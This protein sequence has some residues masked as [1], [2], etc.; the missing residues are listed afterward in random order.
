[1]KIPSDDKSK[2]FS[3]VDGGSYECVKP[4]ISNSQHSARVSARSSYSGKVT[5]HCI[6]APELFRECTFCIVILNYLTQTQT[7]DF[8]ANYAKFRFVSKVFIWMQ[9]EFRDERSLPSDIVER[10]HSYLKL[11]K[12][13]AG[14][15]CQYIAQ[16][17][18]VV[19]WALQFMYLDKDGCR[20][21]E[22][23]AK[24][25]SYIPSV[26]NTRAK[27]H[28]SLSQVTTGIISDEKLLVRSCM[29]FCCAFLQI[30][31][32]FRDA[33]RRNT[34]VEEQLQ[35]LL[36]ECK[37]DISGLR[38]TAS[39][40]HY[41][42]DYKYMAAAVFSSEDCALKEFLLS[43]RVDFI[44]ALRDSGEKFSRAQADTYIKSGLTV[45]GG[46]EFSNPTWPGPLLFVNL[47]YLFLIKHTP[48]EEICFA[49]LLGSDRIQQAGINDL[50]L[51][52]IKTS[53]SSISIE[54]TKRR[55]SEY[56]QQSP[57]HPRGSLRYHA[58][59][60]YVNVRASFVN[61]FPQAE[62]KLFDVTE[63]GSL[64]VLESSFFR[65]L[66][67][68]SLPHTLL[69][70]QMQGI[71]SEIAPFAKILEQIS[72]HNDELRKKRVAAQKGDEFVCG[73]KRQ[74]ITVN[75]IAHSRAILDE[76]PVHH[77][78]FGA[79]KSEET[80]GRYSEEVVG[81][82]ATAHS[83]GVKE[84]YYIHASTTKYRL[85]KRAGFASLVGELMVADARK[86]NDLCKKNRYLTV[87]QIKESLGWK[88]DA[89]TLND[90]QEFDALL[91]AHQKQGWGI[92]PFGQLERGEDTI[93]IISPVAAALLI[94]YREEC[95]NQLENLSSI[96]E[97]RESALIMQIAYA[98][99]VLARFD[100]KTVSEAQDLMRTRKFPAPIIR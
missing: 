11:R 85:E 3:L 94:S 53:S 46:L 98:D 15:I 63:P 9:E 73:K 90:F 1:M 87:E 48:A 71:S 88:A 43:N 69:Y 95:S 59:T 12:L 80:F 99:A 72:I 70:S 82:T 14:S 54:Y 36:R 32:D 55:S 67:L 33:L 19:V 26:P 93:I 27:S 38:W 60:T 13:S 92:T 2:R 10:Y 34:Q 4:P 57:L 62:D 97:L 29:R 58:Y 50:L 25:F 6:E 42:R 84:R 56:P 18:K 45:G 51:S 61:L 39:G 44:R 78:K 89:P 7:N 64:Q 30:M 16:L 28:P 35:K 100:R 8:D 37:G 5:E 77:N 76:D 40:G 68:A 20:Q 52:D 41:K 96:E 24:I 47:D 66:I 91:V 23:P 17:R 83:F 75:I 21:Q 22:E 31:N 74:S 79:D 81:A 86:I 49:W 65:P